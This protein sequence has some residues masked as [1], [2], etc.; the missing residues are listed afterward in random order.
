MGGLAALGGAVVDFAVVD[1]DAGGLV[2]G[3]SA[4]SGRDGTSQST[5]ASHREGKL[6][7]KLRSI[8]YPIERRWRSWKPTWERKANSDPVS[9]SDLALQDVPCGSK[10]FPP[11]NHSP[12]LAV[13][14]S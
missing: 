11:G 3:V 2:V 13:A 8:V 4:S 9:S 14:L 6:N 12:S 5:M 7:R 1:F 10:Y